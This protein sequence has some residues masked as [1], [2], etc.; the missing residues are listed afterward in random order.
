MLTGQ[1]FI[2]KQSSRAIETGVSGGM[3]PVTIAAGEVVEIVSGPIEGDR[4]VDVLYK[5]RSVAMFGI[6]LKTHGVEILD[7]EHQKL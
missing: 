6:D 7:K 4:M 2:L 1:K 5:G 3:L